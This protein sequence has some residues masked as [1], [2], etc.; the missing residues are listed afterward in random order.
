MNAFRPNLVPGQPL[1]IVDTGAPGHRS[2][3]PAAFAAASYSQQGN[4]GRN[5]LSGFGMCQLDLA[6]RREFRLGEQAKIQVRLEAFNAL[7]HQNLGLPNTGFCL[8]PT[9]SGGTDLVHQAG[10]SF[11]R[12]TNI[13]TDPRALEFALKFHW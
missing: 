5:V 11:G 8:P 1:W 3:N 13:A 12:I 9:E 4:L 2:L 10:C 6:A 7:N